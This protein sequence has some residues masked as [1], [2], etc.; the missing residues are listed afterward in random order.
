MS[1]VRL[2]RIMFK[3]TQ[4]ARIARMFAFGE[5]GGCHT[6]ITESTE[7]SPSAKGVV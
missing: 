1:G 4:I 5:G 6:E 2:R 3:V 7:G